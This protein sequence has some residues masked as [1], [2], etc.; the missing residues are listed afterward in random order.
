MK[1]LVDTIGNVKYFFFLFFFIS[2]VVAILPEKKFATSLTNGQSWHLLGNEQQKIKFSEIPSQY[3]HVRQS[4]L[5]DTSANLYRSWTP[6]H[7]IEPII[8]TSP[9]FIPPKFLAIPIQ[10][11]N[12]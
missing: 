12:K 10:G 4:S 8:L 3:Q 1:N 11:S 2:L 7:G 5:R 9:S 6:S